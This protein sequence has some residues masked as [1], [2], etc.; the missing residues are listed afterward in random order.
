MIVNVTSHVAVADPHAPIGRGGWGLGYAASKGAF[1]RVAGILAVELGDQ[2]LRAFNL[3]PG[4]VD[5]ERQLAN[6]QANGLAGH[7]RGR[8]PACPAR[9]SPGWPSTVPAWPTAPP[10]GPRRWPSSSACTRTGEHPRT[11]SGPRRPGVGPESMGPGGPDGAK[12]AAENPMLEVNVADRVAVM[13][14]NRPEARNALSGR[15]GGPDRRVLRRP[16]PRPDVA[17]IILTGADPAF[18]AG[19]DLRQLSTE[20]EAV[21][22]RRQA[23]A[24]AHL[25]MLPRPRPPR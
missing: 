1:H 25:G 5:T 20:I 6:A 23:S 9:W 19:F 14:L 18:C 11:A 22:Q 2:G 24:A 17:A 15:A 10:C 13:T 16:R 8:P 4:Y 12:K 21:Q 7:Y 3:D